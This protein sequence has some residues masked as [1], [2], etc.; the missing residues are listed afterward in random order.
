MSLKLIEEELAGFLASSDAEVLCLKGKWGVGK[1][2]TWERLLK[3]AKSKA[4]GLGLT[5]YSYVTLFGINSLD[6]LRYSIFENT[7]SGVDITTEPS[8]ESFSTLVSKGSDIARKGKPVFEI[9]SAFFNKKGV[10]DILLKAGFLGVRKQLVCL[11]DLERAGRGL[12]IR[13]VL[14]LVSFLKSKRGC[15]VVLLLNDEQLADDPKK[16][17]EKQLEKVADTILKFQLSPSEALAIALPDTDPISE[18][19]KP[20]ISTLKITNIRVIKKIE[21]LAR[22]IADIL[23]DSESAIMKQSMAAVVLAGWAVFEPA[24]APP[25]EYIRTYNGLRN[26][27]K[28]QEK[29]EGPS[30]DDRLGPYPYQST[31]ELDAVIIDGVVDGFFDPKLL[32]ERATLIGDRR[33][34]A[35]GGEWF[36]KVWDEMYHGSLVVDDDDFLDELFKSALHDATVITPLNMNSA[37]SVLRLC[38]QDK[39]ADELAEKYLELRKDEP[40][41]FFDLANHHFTSEEDLDRS[42]RAAFEKM[43]LSFV[44]ERDPFEVL[45]SIGEG[46]GWRFVDTVLMSKQSAGDL[47]SLFERLRGRHVRTSIEA[48]ISMAG[49]QSP[50]AKALKASATEALRTIAGKSKLRA[51]KV[52]RFGVFLEEKMD[53]A[54]APAAG[55]PEA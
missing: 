54:E 30:Y 53:E 33:K 27:L 47:A 11:D 46:R 2:Y 21:K 22:R 9:I 35:E 17:F 19:L 5:S 55:A 44:D 4:N 8:L 26:V 3:A 23:G 6:D 28:T 7:V 45:N 51:R 40:P 48:V 14:G 13:D 31:D 24:A 50:E 38:G 42:L 43:R 18:G 20:L 29:E 32:L 25:V 1:T 16:E 39:R 36:S 15:K 41:E 52:A 49:G 12:D 10:T 37:I 34:K